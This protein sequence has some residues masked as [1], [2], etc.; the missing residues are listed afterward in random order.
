MVLS[1]ASYVDEL[2]ITG[3]ARAL[4][5]WLRLLWHGADGELLPGKP[6]GFFRGA[7][8]DGKLG[9]Q[10]SYDVVIF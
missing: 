1:L 9:W 4:P 7:S 10:R 3:C 8:A 2:V 6:S 5:R